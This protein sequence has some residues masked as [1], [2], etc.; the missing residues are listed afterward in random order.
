MCPIKPV[1]EE[2][3]YFFKVEIEKRKKIEEEKKDALDKEQKAKLK[4]LHYMHCPKCGMD[5]VEVSHHKINIDKC[6]S[7]GGIWLDEGELEHIVDVEK[8]TIGKFLNLFKN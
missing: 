1:A 2:D 4:D 6:L 7:C 5:L 3:E 8:G